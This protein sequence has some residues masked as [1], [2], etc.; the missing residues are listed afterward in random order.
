M[1]KYIGQHIFDFISRFRNN[2]YLEDLSTSTDINVLVVDSDGKVSKNTNTSRT[3]Q[4]T[5]P[6]YVA[7]ITDNTN[8]YHRQSTSFLNWS[9]G[10]DADPTSAFPAADLVTNW[11]TMPYNG[12]ITRVR[13]Q[14]ISNT[15]DPFRFYIFKGAASSDAASLDLTTVGFVAITPPTADESYEYNAG[16][17]FVSL[18]AGDRVYVFFKKTSGS[19]SVNNYYNISIEGKYTS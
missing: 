19:G 6:G 16:T 12:S 9:G 11:F 2:V 14:G 5:V 18:S 3:F 10:V 17:S 1:I 15:T 13:V 7:G 4:I 8:Y